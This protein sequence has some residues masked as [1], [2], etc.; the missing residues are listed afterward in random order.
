M[1]FLGIDIGKRTHVASLMSEES[2]VILKG[3]SFPNTTEGADSLIERISKYSEAPADFVVGMEATGHYW[4]SIFSY[5]HESD[6]LIHVVNPL[7]TDDWRKG[8]EIRKRINDIIDSALIADLMRYG[9]FVETVL[10]DENVFSLKQL[11]RYRAYLVGTASDFK[12]KIIAVLD[13]VFPEYALIFTKQGIFGKA[14]KELLL[15]FSSPIELEEILAETLAQYLAELSRNR[16]KPEKADQLKQAASTSFGVKF[17]QEAFTFQL[18]SMIE[19]LKFIENQV[20]E[21]EK[22]IKRIMSDLDSVILII[23]GIGPINGATILGEI[24]DI[25][26]FSNPKKLVA[27]A[28]IDASVSQSGQYEAT[29]NVMNKRGSPYLRKALF[30]AAL[31]A[32][33]CDPVFRAFYQKKI[34]EG[35]H[36]LT[37]LGAVSRKL[38]YVIHAILTK[39]EHYKI[40]SD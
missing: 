33:Q 6:F 30:S 15:E 11:S 9:S 10:S 31:V 35:K 25:H 18:R 32:S 28:G 39:N 4:L 38:C 7:Q 8:T 17:A 40:V 24:G 22:E 19:Q 27:Y 2:K 34:S 3:F 16:I 14:S 13:Q 37:A 26:Q 36:H 23:P 5:L 20:K 29:H 21:T 1:Y 12:R